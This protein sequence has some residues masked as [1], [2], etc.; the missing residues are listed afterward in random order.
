MTMTTPNKPRE[1]GI[2]SWLPSFLTDHLSR[3]KRTDWPT[4]GTEEQIRFLN[5]WLGVF[6]GQRVT[7]DE[8]E[9]ASR[10]LLTTPPRFS[11]GHLPAVLAAVKTIRASKGLT[12][13]DM[14]LEGSRAAS[15]DCRY[16]G[17]E[18]MV[19]VYKQGD[20]RGPLHASASC[21]CKIGRLMR[22]MNVQKDATLSLRIPD[23]TDI[24]AMDDP[25]WGF[26]EPMESDAPPPPR[27]TGS[28]L[29]QAAI[30]LIEQFTPDLRTA[31]YPKESV[32]EIKENVGVMLERPATD[33]FGNWAR[34]TLIALSRTMLNDHRSLELK[35]W[36]L[37]KME[38]KGQDQTVE[39][40]EQPPAAASST[41]PQRS[42]RPDEARIKADSILR[43]E[44][45]Y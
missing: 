39:C 33:P 35:Q 4:I 2:K 31:I 25:R 30:H 26:Q 37:A 43:N 21:I 9:E 6:K 7:K 34:R 32:E 29:E 41:R 22:R 18:G 5:D 16:C 36:A 12:D 24:L 45:D 8:A 38:G 17:G 15:R 20:A 1:P 11:D 19:S 13:P 28:K 40:V 10:M 42:T 14:T 44:F 27:S 3:Y 23:L